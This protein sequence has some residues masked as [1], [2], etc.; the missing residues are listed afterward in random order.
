MRRLKN[1][2]KES[3]IE[4]EARIL[5]SQNGNKTRERIV[6]DKKKEKNKFQCREDSDAE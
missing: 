6:I 1:R 4:R 5:F 3:K 2:N